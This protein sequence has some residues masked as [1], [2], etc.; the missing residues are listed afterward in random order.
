VLHEDVLIKIYV[1]S[2]E[3][4]KKDCLAHSCDPKSIPSSTKLI[5]EFLRQYRPSTQSLQ[6]Y[7]QELK[8]TLCRECFSI[9]DETIYEEKLEEYL[10][11]EDLDET[12]DEDEVSSLPLDEDIQ[13]PAS[14]AHKE[15]NMMSYNPFENFDDVLFHDCG[16]EENFQKDLDEVFLVEGLKET[17][18]S[19][20]PFEEAKVIQY[21]E[22][23]INLYDAGEIMEHPPY[24]VEDHI[25]DFI[26]IGR[27]KWD[28][29]C[30]IFYMDP[31][32]DIEGASWIKDT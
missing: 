17:L 1:S 18:S 14:P 2:L 24:T 15:D 9:N 11:E 8:H 20:S 29:G 23:V 28:L 27:C 30:F 4:S 5:E 13:T 10:D 12:Y 31:I 26:Q 25:D 7:F 6:D 16:N 19:T 3:S 22:E 21:C 32:Y